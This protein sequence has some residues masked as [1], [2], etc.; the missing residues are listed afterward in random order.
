MKGCKFVDIFQFINSRDIR[1]YL[2]NVNYGFNP[3][4]TA[5]LSLPLLLNVYHTIIDEEQVKDT[6]PWNITKE[7]LQLA[8]IPK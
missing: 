3:L 4:E 7:G 5:W 2:K 6:R 1:D 8:G